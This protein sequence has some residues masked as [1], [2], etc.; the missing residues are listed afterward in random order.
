MILRALADY[1]ARKREADPSALPPRGFERRAIPFLLVV[2]GEGAAVN[3]VDTRESEADK[4]KEYV[5]PQ[6]V[7]K[8]GDN[9]QGNL[10]WDNLEYALKI[11]R[12]EQPPEK[13][14]KRH[15]AFVKRI[16]EFAERL[17]G[18]A[19][20]ESGVEAVLLFLRNLDVSLAE[21]SD[22]WEAAKKLNANV[23]FA[24]DSD[25]SRPIFESDAVRAELRREAAAESGESGFCLVSGA[26]GAIGR[27]HPLFQGVRG[28]KTSGANLVSF[29]LD[30]FRSYGKEQGANAPVAEGLI[31]DY[32]A[33]LRHL[34]RRDSRQKVQVGDATT[35]FWAR[36]SH[37]LEESIAALFGEPAK[38][39]PDDSRSR[40]VRRVVESPKTG[41][42]NFEEDLTPFYVLG[43]SPNQSRVSIRF[44]HESTAGK[45]AANV[46][47]HFAD[48]DV[49]RGAN[50]P[51]H[52]GIFSLLRCLAVMRK[53]EN[54]P[55]NLAG[56]TMRAILSGG[57]YPRAILQC[58]V[59]RCRAER[60]VGY[61]RAA[62][63]RGYLSRR[64]RK[65]SKP[66]IPKML[67]EN[68]PSP[69]YCLGRLFAAL[70]R[71]QES[72]QP[73]INATIRDRFYG[74]AS[75][76]PAIVFPNL[77][78]LSRHHLGKLE[79]GG[80]FF[81]KTIGEIINN[82]SAAPLPPRLDLESQ[83][84]FAVGYYHQR[85]RFFRK[86]GGDS[87]AETSQQKEQK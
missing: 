35:I 21:K 66:E 37:D 14:R 48:I 26:Q 20:I 30:S 1:C 67:D 39:D 73:G 12:P 75:S 32:T 41:G 63:L 15:D 61:H 70:E 86:R 76:T 60:E 59:N 24:L 22:G 11:A 9:F 72:A 62:L 31:A 83:G 2:N 34:L 18:E 5:A 49:E 71:L 28:A 69:G 17:P 16:A 33:A 42:K 45:I 78:K 43:L 36:E 53:S 50:Y 68:N 58:A 7:Q 8:G 23:A 82:L 57:G 47:G 74:A 56:E 10:L 25:P 55:P 13:V 52:P 40:A 44:W 80:G 84:L 29:N 81:D 3:F 46:R 27:L 65:D 77:L 19:R 79:G 54:I 38:D 4:G 85:Q 64:A 87:S 6:A 51:P